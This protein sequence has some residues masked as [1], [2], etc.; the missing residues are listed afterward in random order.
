M[1]RGRLG[2]RGGERTRART[3]R[4]SEQGRGMR[5]LTWLLSVL[6]LVKV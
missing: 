6:V 5:Q 4:V 1:C 2:L 3:A